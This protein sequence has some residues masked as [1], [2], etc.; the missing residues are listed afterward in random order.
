[1]V[2]VGNIGN[3]LIAKSIRPSLQRI[4][5][6]E[7]LLKNRN[8]PTVEMIYNELL[9]EMPTLSKTT[10]YN[11]LK[12]FVENNV[13]II[14]NIEDNETRYDADV[15]VHGHFKCVQCDGVFDFAVDKDMLSFSGM[16]GFSIDEY[17]VYLKG[18]C[19]VC[20]SNKL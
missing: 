18:L 9:I 16:E 2:E 10:I 13:A 20:K 1:M 15:S 3:Y 19:R 5:I 14:I 6:L 4:K 12:L 8:H 11:T 17:H 7:Y